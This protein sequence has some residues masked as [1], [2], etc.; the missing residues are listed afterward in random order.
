MIDGG[1]GCCTRESPRFGSLS[2][3]P[4]TLSAELPSQGLGFG[5]SRVTCGSTTLTGTRPHPL[6]S[7]SQRTVV[8]V[9]RLCCS[10]A[11]HT[12]HTA[13]R[14]A[15][16]RL[17]GS[18]SNTSGRILGGREPYGVLDLSWSRPAGPLL[19]A[20]QALQT[21]RLGPNPTP[22]QENPVQSSG[23]CSDGELSEGNEQ[24]HAEMCEGKQFAAPTD[25][26]TGP[27]R[28]A[29]TSEGREVAVATAG[30]PCRV[31]AV[32]SERQDDAPELR[33]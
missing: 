9:C 29:N 31:C 26:L 2:S 17:D 28:H 20:L 33:R 16:W 8:M 1:D 11:A 14:R 21:P 6:S 30:E 12:H 25:L 15:Y 24:L 19:Q 22:R 10:T 5:P 32:V 4:P 27:T 7:C 3:E 13:Q 23:Y 18:E